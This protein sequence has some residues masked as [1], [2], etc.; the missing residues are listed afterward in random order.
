M[1]FKTAEVHVDGTLW[2]KIL[3]PLPDDLERMLKATAKHAS[4]N[5]EAIRQSTE[6]VRGAEVK[7]GQ[8]LRLA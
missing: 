4:P 7:R 1:N 3:D 6:E 5:N 2:N 8:H